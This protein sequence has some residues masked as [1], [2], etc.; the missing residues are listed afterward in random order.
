MNIAVDVCIGTRGV[1][2]LERAGHTVVRCAEHGERDEVWFAAALRCEAALVISGD[3]D[4]EILCWDHN[5]EFFKARRH[6]SDV[7]VVERLLVHLSPT[8]HA[9]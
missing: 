3:S 9:L 8:R 4:I 7:D 6:E 1:R 2:A 5:V